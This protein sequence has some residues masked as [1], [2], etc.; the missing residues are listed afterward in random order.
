MRG[1]LNFN[2]QDRD[3]DTGNDI[4]WRHVIHAS[5]LFR[6]VINTAKWEKEG[7][8]GGGWG[9]GG[10]GERERERERE[11]ERRKRGE[12]Q[13]KKTSKTKSTQRAQTSLVE[14]AY[15]QITQMLDFGKST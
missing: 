9:G 2:A 5:F 15:S 14:A 7:D 8:G 1:Y 6:S 4:C 11:G 10:G 13:K 12:G 3:V